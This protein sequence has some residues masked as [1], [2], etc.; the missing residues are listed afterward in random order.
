MPLFG[1]L[2]DLEEKSADFVT[3]IIL[4]GYVSVIWNFIWILELIILL[5]VIHV[6]GT[7]ENVHRTQEISW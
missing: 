6:K 7:S 2:C 5:I 4:L 3:W 1:D